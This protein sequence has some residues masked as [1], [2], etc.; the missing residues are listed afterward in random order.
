MPQTPPEPQPLPIG[1]VALVQKYNPH[2]TELFPALR[3]T[4]RQEMPELPQGGDSPFSGGSGQWEPKKW[5]YIPRIC[6]YEP[7]RYPPRIE[8]F[9]HR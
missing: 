4:S 3:R 7:P 5:Q 6:A 9:M 2:M 8:C 1:V